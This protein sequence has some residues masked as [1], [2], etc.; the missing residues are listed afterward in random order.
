[1]RGT[2]APR[3]AAVIAL[4][5]VMSLRRQAVARMRCPEWPSRLQ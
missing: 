3:S 5:T 2:A 1:M 4:L